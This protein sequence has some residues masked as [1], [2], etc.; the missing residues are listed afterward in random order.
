M[1]NSLNIY[2]LRLIYV[3]AYVYVYKPVM[4]SLSK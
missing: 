3:P 1:Q 4:T 2:I